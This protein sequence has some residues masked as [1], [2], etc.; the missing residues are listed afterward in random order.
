VGAFAIASLIIFP[1]L[2]KSVSSLTNWLFSSEAE[3]SKKQRI[4]LGYSEAPNNSSKPIA[5][6]GQ[7]DLSGPEQENIKNQDFGLIGV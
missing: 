4:A 3:R 1:S 6:I 5:G 2:P 7:N